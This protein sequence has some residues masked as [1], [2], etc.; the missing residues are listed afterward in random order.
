MI[1]ATQGLA[2]LTINTNEMV[3]ALRS[4]LPFRPSTILSISES[5]CSGL[6]PVV[7]V[8]RALGLNEY[9]PLGTK[10]DARIMKHETVK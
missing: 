8:P 9:A 5:D 3:L 6:P 4:L 10:V 7:I 1:A 2:V